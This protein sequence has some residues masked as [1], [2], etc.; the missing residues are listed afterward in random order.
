M[1]DRLK[2]MGNTAGMNTTTARTNQMNSNRFDPAGGTK[3]GFSLVEILVVLA[4]IAILV[5]AVGL[6]RSGI[7][8]GAKRKA[9]ISDIKVFKMAL[10]VYDTDNGMYPTMQQGLAA[11]ISKP[12]IPPVP[13]NYPSTK[14]I[15]KKALPV[16]PW[17]SDYIYLVPGRQGE[18]FEVIT[19]GNDKRPGG[20]GD[21]ADI[22]SS[23][24]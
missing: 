9:A 7:L 19:H 6:N 14:Y 22:S 4:I 8:S 1:N 24:L 16:D 2:G 11:L 3:G 12:T 13:R 23:D 5:T 18:P 21:D 10:E 17:G 20:E 15:D